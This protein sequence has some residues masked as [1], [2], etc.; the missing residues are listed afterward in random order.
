MNT[1]RKLRKLLFQFKN[2]LDKPT[3]ENVA[4][5]FRQHGLDVSTA[6]VI[7]WSLDPNRSKYNSGIQGPA[8]NPSPQKAFILANILNCNFE[9]IYSEEVP[10]EPSED[11][12][13]AAATE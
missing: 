2:S 5:I 6:T 12:V 7:A 3:W 1:N 13:K 9:D 11:L 8:R 4:N 10:G